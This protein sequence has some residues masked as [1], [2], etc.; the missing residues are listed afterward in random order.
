MDTVYIATIKN[1]YDLPIN[2]ETW[3]SVGFCGFL[4]VMKTI[5]LHY[6]CLL[7]LINI[8]V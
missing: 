8:K 6:K 1:A 5:L 3:Q 4:D 2:V 7:V